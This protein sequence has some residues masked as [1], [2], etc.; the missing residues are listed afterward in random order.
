MFD[1]IDVL[2]LLSSLSLVSVF[3]SGRSVGVVRFGFWG[4]LCA[5][6]TPDASSFP[7]S[8]SS[9]AQAF[10]PFLQFG[11]QLGILFTQSSDQG[12]LL[13]HLINVSHHQGFQA[14]QALHEDGVQMLRAHASSYRR[15]RSKCIPSKYWRDDDSSCVRPGRS[16]GERDS[17]R[18]TWVKTDHRRHCRLVGPVAPTFHS[19]SSASSAAIRSA[20]AAMNASCCWMRSEVRS[21]PRGSYLIIPNTPNQTDTC[22]EKD[23]HR[24]N[25][26][27]GLLSGVVTSGG[28]SPDL[29]W[30]E[31]VK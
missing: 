4:V 5:F 15:H 1:D 25:R 23:R 9:N 19:C 21:P 8:L 30:I 12:I 27:L 26:R 22:G 14:L 28:D 10:L 31:G 7:L 6:S 16:G 18:G 13:P 17:S 29:T 3:S 24:W 2:G 11:S 20:R